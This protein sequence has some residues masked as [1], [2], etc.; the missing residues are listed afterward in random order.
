MK[1]KPP[2]NLHESDAN[3]IVSLWFTGK[4]TMNV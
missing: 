1:K 2:P 3:I 4:V